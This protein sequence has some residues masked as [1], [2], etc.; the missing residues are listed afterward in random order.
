MHGVASMTTPEIGLFG[1]AHTMICPFKC[2]DPFSLHLDVGCQG[3]TV[4]LNVFH[5]P[6]HFELEIGSTFYGM[7]RWLLLMDSFSDFR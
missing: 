4:T 3:S 1:V 5:L 7:R 2:H 6:P